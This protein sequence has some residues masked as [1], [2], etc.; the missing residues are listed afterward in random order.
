[1][2]EILKRLYVGLFAAAI[3]SSLPAMFCLLLSLKVK[4]ARRTGVWITKYRRWT[5]ATD[6]DRFETCVRIATIQAVVIGILA[7][8]TAIALFVSFAVFATP[9]GPPPAINPN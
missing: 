4:N 9:S 6:P 5:Q 2:M 7:G 1:M 8:L 3:F